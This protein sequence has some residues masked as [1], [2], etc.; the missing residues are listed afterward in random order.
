MVRRTDEWPGSI[1]YG[2]NCLNYDTTSSDRGRE[3][4][5]DI[6]K[7]TGQIPDNADWQR[8]TELRLDPVEQT[9]MSRKQR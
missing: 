2:M 8:P 6:R 7:K 5:E 1:W 3:A 9:M 4:A